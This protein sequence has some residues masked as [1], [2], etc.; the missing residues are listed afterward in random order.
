MQHLQQI[1]EEAR[2]LRR[3]IYRIAREAGGGH[4]GG[5]FSAADIIATLYFGD[6]LRYD[7]ANPNWE[8]RDLFI[9]SKGHSCFA[10]YAALLHAGFFAP[11]DIQGICKPGSPFGGHPKNEKHPRCRGVNRILGTWTFVWNR[12]CTC[13]EKNWK[14]PACICNDGRWRM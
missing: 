7:A 1:D 6:V 2:R 11:S 14:R 8:G 3:D 5:A 13:Y 4:I 10:L 9:M 12:E